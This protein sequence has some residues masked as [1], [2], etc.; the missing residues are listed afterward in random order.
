MD[1]YIFFD[2]DRVPPG[3]HVIGVPTLSGFV[4]VEITEAEYRAAVADVEAARR[5]V[6][7][8]AEVLADRLAGAGEP[9]RE[10]RE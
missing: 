4:W 5:L 6:A 2:P 3:L 9:R 1:R 10:A 7:Y 8:A